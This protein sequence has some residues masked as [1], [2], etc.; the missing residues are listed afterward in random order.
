MQKILKFKVC[1]LHIISYSKLTFAILQ[2][3]LS[4]SKLNFYLILVKFKPYPNLNYFKRQKK[5][6]LDILKIDAFLKKG[7]NFDFRIIFL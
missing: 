4:I 3:K 1:Q 2:A 7:K 6:F 5:Q